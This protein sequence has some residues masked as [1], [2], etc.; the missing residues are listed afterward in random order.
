[1][2]HGRRLGDEAPL[3][4]SATDLFAITSA[5]D[6]SVTLVP[7]VITISVLNLAR[8]PWG[9]LR[10]DR[11]LGNTRENPRRATMR[12][13]ALY[14]QKEKDLFSEEEDEVSVIKQYI[15]R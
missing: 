13:R 12:N 15:W 1:M 9:G 5:S 7:G 6:V 3:G 4:V 11:L 2:H 8:W 14:Q 10:R